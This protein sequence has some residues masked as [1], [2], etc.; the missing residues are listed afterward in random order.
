MRGASIDRLRARYKTVYVA[1]VVVLVVPG[2]LAATALPDTQW[3]AV[4]LGLYIGV[5]LT[6]SAHTLRSWP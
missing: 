3:F 5:L 6:H 1:A 2:L 4:S